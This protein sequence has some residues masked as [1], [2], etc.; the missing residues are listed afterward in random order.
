MYIDSL[1]DKLIDIVSVKSDNRLGF[2]DLITDI[3]RITK[4]SRLRKN[5]EYIWICRQ[6]GTHIIDITSNSMSDTE[7]IASN[8]YRGFIRVILCAYRITED[9]GSFTLQ[10][11]NHEQIKKDI[12][13]G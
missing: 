1:I 11:L 5:N 3:S 13:C 9:N 6:N 12:L 10:Q 2:F 7:C 8:I 4:N